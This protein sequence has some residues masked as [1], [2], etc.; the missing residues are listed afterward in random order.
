MSYQAG[1]LTPE[2]NR[3]ERKSGFATSAVA[4]AI[5]RKGTANAMQYPET[6]ALAD[7]M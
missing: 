3:S 1:A 7:G 4:I 2:K 5:D 6:I